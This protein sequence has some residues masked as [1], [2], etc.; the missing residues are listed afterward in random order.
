[1]LIQSLNLNKFEPFKALAFR[2]EVRLEARLEVRLKV[3]LIHRIPRKL[4][5]PSLTEF[6]RFKAPLQVAVNSS[7]LTIHF[8]K[9]RPIANS[10]A[11]RGPGRIVQWLNSN[12][13]KR[14]SS[15]GLA[16][17]N[18]R[19]EENRTRCEVWRSLNDRRRWFET[20]LTIHEQLQ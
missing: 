2:L 17:T 20:L 12:L 18:G 11:C 1:M 9:R 16:F 15:I 8:V 7:R 6:G 19:E 13:F 3:R 10:R 4:D 5:D 14:K